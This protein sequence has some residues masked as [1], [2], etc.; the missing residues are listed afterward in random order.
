MIS[1]L[2]ASEVKLGKLQMKPLAIFGNDV[3]LSGT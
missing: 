1:H 2:G 3:Q